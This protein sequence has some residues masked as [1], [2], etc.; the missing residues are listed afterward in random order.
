MFNTIEFE[1]KFKYEGFASEFEENVKWQNVKRENYG[2][3]FI[4]CSF[5][6]CC[7][8]CLLLYLLYTHDECREV[9]ATG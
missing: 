6:N 4:L 3:D 5:Q 8:L 2:P 7:L 9:C 1:Q